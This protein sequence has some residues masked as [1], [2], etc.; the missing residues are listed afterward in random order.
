M[1]D[2]SVVVLSLDGDVRFL[3]QVCICYTGCVVEFVLLEDIKKTSEYGPGQ[4]AVG[5]PAGVGRLGHMI[6][7]RSFPSP[8]IL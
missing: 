1:V 6:S 7:K 2:L 3:D 8:A 4:S 5:I